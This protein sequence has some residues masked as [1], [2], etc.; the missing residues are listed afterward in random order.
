MRFACFGG[1]CEVRAADP[2]AEAR[3]RD[4]LIELHARFTRFDPASELERLNADP[5]PA[6]RASAELRALARAVRHA[7]ERTG[8]LVDG[9]LAAE[10]A[11]A[12]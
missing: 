11:A 1:T 9:T 5:R 10:I 2:A 6:V 3:A 12:G 8:G 4:R 7:G